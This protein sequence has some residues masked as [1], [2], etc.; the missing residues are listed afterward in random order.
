VIGDDVQYAQDGGV[1]H[2]ID[3]D[4]KECKVEVVR[5]ECVSR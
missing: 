4:G 2:V 3:A 1:L 5:Q